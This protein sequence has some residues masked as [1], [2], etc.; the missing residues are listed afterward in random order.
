ML[1]H[2]S[3]PYPPIPTAQLTLLPQVVAPHMLQVSCSISLRS[4][5]H[6]PFILMFYTLSNSLTSPMPFSTLSM[7]VDC[8]TKCGLAMIPNPHWLQIP[9]NVWCQLPRWPQI[10]LS[11]IFQI[12]QPST[13]WLRYFLFWSQVS[14]KVHPML[15]SVLPE[16]MLGIIIHPQTRPFFRN[17]VQFTYLEFKTGYDMG[18]VISRVRAHISVWNSNCVNRQLLAITVCNVLPVHWMCAW[19]QPLDL[20]PSYY[21]SGAWR[22]P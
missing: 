15:W 19:N 7:G 14:W 12:I 3:T 20:V 5:L 18:G 22:R 13:K 11:S 8:G 6:V 16:D 17:I 9:V 4:G 10:L 2:A 1:N 21:R